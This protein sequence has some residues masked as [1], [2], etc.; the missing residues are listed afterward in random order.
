MFSTEEKF[1]NILDWKFINYLVNKITK[2]E[3]MGYYVLISVHTSD[4]FMQ[5]FRDIYSYTNDTTIHNIGYYTTYT[6]QDVNW[7]YRTYLESGI[8]YY[9]DIYDEDRV[10][11]EQLCKSYGEEISKY[12]EYFENGNDDGIYIKKKENK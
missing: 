3:D 1:K 5:G 12:G 10:T 2:Y 8:F 7:T 6:E 9:I 11:N 4:S